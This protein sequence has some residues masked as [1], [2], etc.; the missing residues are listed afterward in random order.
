M[1]GTAGQSFGAFAAEGMTLL[2]EG[3]ANDYV[4]KGLSGGELILRPWGKLAR[5]PEAQVIMGN[6]ALYGATAG[7]LFAA[8]SAGERFAIRN[9]G[10]TAVVEGVGEHA[11]EYMTGG[12]VVVLGEAGRNF[13]A[14][15]TGGVAYVWDPKRSF[16]S[17]SKVHAEFVE[18]E[19]LQRCPSSEQELVRDLL[20][21][22]VGKTG[23]RVGEQ[24]LEHWPNVVCE[25]V[26][27]APKSAPAA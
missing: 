1:R 10:A 16:Q 6:V 24:L 4:G 17:G 9:S 15:M 19:A 12:L 7:S 2:L 20:V 27:V 25:M 23:S 18:V 3:Q 13:G 11:C 8:G 22:H 5:T 26:R 21:Q 14:G